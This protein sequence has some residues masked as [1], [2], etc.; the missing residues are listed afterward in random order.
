ME[1][2]YLNHYQQINVKI[3]SATPI[4]N[5]NYKHKYILM[6]YN[7]IPHTNYPNLK[8]I[9]YTT[10][11]SKPINYLIFIDRYNVCYFDYAK[12]SYCRINN[13]SKI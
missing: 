11:S 7:I 4:T 10:Q 13:N 12:N 2:I 8:C 1:E 9:N 3:N 5:Y 6:N